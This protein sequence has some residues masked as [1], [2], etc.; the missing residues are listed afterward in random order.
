MRNYH[1]IPTTGYLCFLLL[2]FIIVTPVNA[3]SSVKDLEKNLK[4]I[5]DQIQELGKQNLK[6][7]GNIG[8]LQ[9]QLRDN[10]KH[11]SGNIADLS[12]LNEK[13]DLSQNELGN[14]R[15]QQQQRQSSLKQHQA[16]LAS[17]LR[18]AHRT[19]R[20]ANLQGLWGNLTITGFLRNRTWGTYLQRAHM[21]QIHRLE[22]EQAEILSTEEKISTKLRKNKGLKADAQ[23]RRGQL[24]AEKI[25]RKKTIDQLETALKGSRRKVSQLKSSRKELN[26]LLKQLTF[27]LAN[28]DLFQAGKQAFSKLKG[29]LRWPLKG[30][31]THLSSSQGVRIIAPEGKQVR[32]ISHGRIIFADWM[33]GFGLLTI[34]DHGEGFMSL[35]GNNQS[36]FKKPGE[37]VEPGAVIAASG[38]SGGRTEPGL[39]FEI[40]KNAKPLNPAKW[41]TSS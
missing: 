36:L 41:C 11:I 8:K 38:K 16:L 12:R 2:I 21:E 29:T 19:G 23:E 32:A 22:S 40:R 9:G 39:Y 4:T 26:T 33:R 25:R 17:Q 6:K 18:A 7:E 37:W 27:A 24:A 34:I 1:I 20:L 5:N 14:L 3:A 15:R 10:E 13:I 30:K 31:I 28:P 35:Y